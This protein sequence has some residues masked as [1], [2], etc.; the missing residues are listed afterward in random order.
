M[1]LTFR[2]GCDGLIANE[3]DSTT[4]CQGSSVKGSSAR[5]RNTPSATTECRRAHVVTTANVNIRSTNFYV[6]IEPHSTLLATH[7]AEY[8]RWCRELTPRNA[9]SLISRNS[10]FV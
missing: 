6:T 3:H 10:R 4:D 2:R 9:I 8:P 1:L 5:H 7:G